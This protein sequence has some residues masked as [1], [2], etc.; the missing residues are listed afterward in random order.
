VRLTANYTLQFA[1]GTG[2]SSGT[3]AFLINSG[4]PNLRTTLPLGFD[5]RHQIQTTFDFRY[6][7]GKRYNGPVWF[8]KRVFENAGV[9]MVMIANSGT[10]YSRSSFYTQDAGTGGRAILK[11]SPNGSRLPFQY[12]INLRVDKTFALTYGKKEGDERKTADLQLYVLVQN[13][14]NFKN[15]IG[16]YR[17]TGNPDDD[18][19][20]NAATSQAIIQSQLDPIS[21]A[22]LYTAKVRSPFNFSRPRVIRIG[23]ILNF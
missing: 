16:V 13:L 17:A 5:V 7:E 6:D 12:R 14:L 11:G 23:A 22:D 18:G 10:P 8:G 21:F 2:T 3:G 20:L 15:I 1:D 19:Y 9:N 4:Q